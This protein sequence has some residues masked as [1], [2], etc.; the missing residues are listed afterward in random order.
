MSTSVRDSDSDGSEADDESRS[1]VQE[2]E[3]DIEEGPPQKEEEEEGSDDEAGNSSVDSMAFGGGRMTPHVVEPNL[4]DQEI[5]IQYLNEHSDQDSAVA[6]EDMSTSSPP[7]TGVPDATNTMDSPQSLMYPDLPTPAPMSP[8]IA[9]SQMSDALIPTSDDSVHL[10]YPE[11]GDDNRPDAQLATDAPPQVVVPDV[12]LGDDAVVP[13]PDELKI[14]TPNGALQANEGSPPSPVTHILSSS[15]PPGD[16]STEDPSAFALQPSGLVEPTSGDDNLMTEPK[17]LDEGDVHKE[18]D[19][20][21][22]PDYLKPYAVAPVEWDP[23][24]KVR[25]PILLR[26]TLRPYQQSG[27]EWLASLHTNNLNGILADE[28]GLGYIYNTFVQT[29]Y[30]HVRLL[31]KPSRRSLF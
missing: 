18:E 27:L 2:N 17:Q 14:L 6:V 28:M 10:E 22:I 19:N 25:T 20:V 21:T 26:G 8:S 7:P 15:L 4:S 12:G 29:S 23:E 13:V 31:G 16:T 24:T 3:T 5:E 1:S 30:T 9:P 11:E